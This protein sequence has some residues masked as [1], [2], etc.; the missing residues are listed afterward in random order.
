VTYNFIKF[1]TGKCCLLPPCSSFIRTWTTLKA[2]HMKI[3]KH[4]CMHLKCFMEIVSFMWS[5][6]YYRWRKYFM[7]V[8]FKVSTTTQIHLERTTS[9]HSLWV[10]AECQQCWIKLLYYS[11][12][13]ETSDIGRS[14]HPLS[15]F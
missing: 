11:F 8:C 13:A 2:F 1:T 15:C 9:A 4:F 6:L 7:C 3:Y 5:N 10:L 12:S 14:V